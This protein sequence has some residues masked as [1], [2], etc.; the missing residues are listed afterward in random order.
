MEVIKYIVIAAVFYSAGT[1]GMKWWQRHQLEESFLKNGGSKK[2]I[3]LAVSCQGKKHCI[4][5]YVAPWCPVCRA[6]EQSFFAIQKF[7]QRLRPDTGFGVVIGDASAKDNAR[8]KADLAYLEPFTDDTGLLME[9]RQ[10][11]KFPTWI[12]TDGEGNETYRTSGGV[13]ASDLSEVNAILVHF[14]KL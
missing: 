8:M 3:G 9:M 1:Y 11:D 2:T 5:V 10:V 7:L 4:T 14:L 6:S 12:V 13:R